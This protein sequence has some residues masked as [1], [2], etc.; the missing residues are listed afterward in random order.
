M[1][2]G[3]SAVYRQASGEQTE[4]PGS[5][6]KTFSLRGETFS[7]AK[8]TVEALELARKDLSLDTREATYTLIIKGFLKYG[9]QGVKPGKPAGK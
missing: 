9:R 5:A 3:N 8:E 6:T 2:S 7:L 4:K 1:G